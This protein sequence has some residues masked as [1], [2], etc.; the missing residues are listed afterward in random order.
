MKK[1]FTLLFILFSVFALNAFGQSQTA[2][3]VTG[4]VGK[5]EDSESQD[6]PSSAENENKVSTV[7]FERRIVELINRKRIEN[8]LQPLIWNEDVA[9]VARVHSQNMARFK[10][11]SHVGLDGLA[12]DERAD[13]LGVRKWRA[14]GENIAYN[15]G[16]EN[17][18][19]FAF[20]G[21]MKSQ[22]HRQNLLNTRWKE[23]GVGIAVAQDG[24]Y[25]FTQVFL[26]R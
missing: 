6:S 21:W 10:F 24:T 13:T 11:F 22:P 16:F 12:V 15:R 8:G 19:E 3:Q 7:E 14:I 4:F 5:T 2:A 18:C 25:Y 1:H 20:E 9:R 23:T 26:V 17:P